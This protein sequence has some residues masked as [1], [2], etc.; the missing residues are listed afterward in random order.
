MTRLEAYS[1]GMSLS[2]EIINLK[3]LALIDSRFALHFGIP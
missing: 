3:L 1:I 2:P